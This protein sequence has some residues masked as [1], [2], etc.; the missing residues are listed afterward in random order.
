MNVQELYTKFGFKLYT[1]GVYNL[2]LFGVRRESAI[3]NKFD[4]I[5]CIACNTESGW[6]TWAIPATT[7]AGSSVL[8]A[9]FGGLGGTATLP[10]STV[11]GGM[12][13][14]FKWG[15]HK[16]KYPAFQQ[17][18][19][20]RLVRDSDKNG[21]NL[22]T[23]EIQE[24]LNAGSISEGYF[25]INIHHASSI[26]VSNNVDNWSWGCQV[27]ASIHDWVKFTSI[28]ERSV[29]IYGD[30]VTYTLFNEVDLGMSIDEF[31][32]EMNGR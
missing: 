31:Y 19:P 11:K 6:L 20:F 7:D 15:T 29:S 30:V 28:V 1:K 5:I 21:V 22:T 13:Y 4:D 14:K 32:T 18:E 9:D 8:N 17:A 23:T 16:G 12:Q 26:G 10:A 27:I 3:P 2:N 25:G 24:L